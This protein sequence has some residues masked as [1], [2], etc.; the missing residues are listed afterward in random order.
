MDMEI[1]SG[2]TT[3]AY[4]LQEQLIQQNYSVLDSSFQT[5]VDFRGYNQFWNSFGKSLSVSNA[6]CNLP[7][8]RSAVDFADLLKTKNKDTIFKGKRVVFVH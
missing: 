6:S 3:R 2:K 7:V 8:I 5:G 4:R 1:A